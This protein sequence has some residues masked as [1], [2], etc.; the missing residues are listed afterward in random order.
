MPC[1][2]CTGHRIPR[3]ELAKHVQ[4][5]LTDRSDL[6]AGRD[7]GVASAV[8]WRLAGL[9][10]KYAFLKDCVGWGGMPLHMVEKDIAEG[11]EL[12]VDR[13]PLAAGAKPPLPV[14]KR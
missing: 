5:V 7:F 6:T 10:T 4:L 8:T 9:S 3:R 14:L 12:N 13:T 1:V 11:H 2:E